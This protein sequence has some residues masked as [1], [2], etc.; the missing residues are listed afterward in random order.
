[1]KKL[2]IFLKNLDVFILSLISIAFFYLIIFDV[3]SWYYSAI[4]D[5]YAFFNYA[6]DIATGNIRLSIFPEAG[7]VSIFSQKGVYDVVPVASSLFQAIIMKIFGI[8]HQGWIISSILIVIFSFWFFY[9]LV[10]DYLGRATAIV[11]S[12]IFISSHYL[13][14]FTHLGYWN[15]QVFFPPLAAFFFFFRG[16][17]TKKILLLFLAGIFS[18]LG[19]YT[20]FS[21]RL[22]L[23][24]VSLFLLWN[25]KQFIQQKK[26]ITAFFIGFILLIIP[27]FLTNKDI[28]I[29]QMFERSALGSTEIPNNDRLLYFF[30]N[31]YSSF[32]AFYQNSTTSHFVS[33]SLVDSI[34]VILFTL[35]LIQMM[36]SWKKFCFVLICFAAALITVG[37]FSPYTYTPITRLFFLLPFTSFIG[38]FALIQANAFLT[39][40]FHFLHHNLLPAITVFVILILNINR[41]YYQTPLKMDLTPEALTIRALTSSCKNSLSPSIIG[42][43]T[44]LLSPALSSYKIDAL[45]INRDSVTSLFNLQNTDCLILMQPQYQELNYYKNKLLFSYI[46]EKVTDKAGNRSVILFRR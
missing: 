37:G 13:W 43:T 18:G 15:I 25:L 27:Y 1:M 17:K 30:K 2:N 20:Y 5:E 16:T 38:A 42:K 44:P 14:A 11:A 9:F 24:L 22:T 6:K 32:V 28:V 3:N 31:L 23:L 35:G 45:L 41:F 4:G 46:Y 12:I 26:L 8:S 7:M 10:K 36:I 34:T 40:K 33:G 39:R 21:A 29:S 19:F